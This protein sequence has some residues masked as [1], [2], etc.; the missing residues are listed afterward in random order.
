M[1][2]LIVVSCNESVPRGLLQPAKMQA[3]MWDVVRAEA[4]S[5]EIAA[6]DTTKTALDENAR[7]LAQVFTI[8]KTTREIFDKSYAWYSARPDLMKVMLDSIN[9]QQTRLASLVVNTDSEKKDST[10]TPKVPK[11]STVPKPKFKDS[12]IQHR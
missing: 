10:V 2:A 9:A 1:L 7:L 6:R 5:Q 4:L 11:D 8:H 3:I 12:I